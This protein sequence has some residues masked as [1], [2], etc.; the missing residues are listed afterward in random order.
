MLWSP[1]SV[2][3]RGQLAGPKAAGRTLCME[4][5]SNTLCVWSELKFI[6]VQGVLAAV[7]RFLCVWFGLFF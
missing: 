7:E 2:S 6:I 3:S 5:L 4:F 1:M